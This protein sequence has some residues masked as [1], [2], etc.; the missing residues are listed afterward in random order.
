M[1]FPISLRL[2]SHQ[3]IMLSMVIAQSSQ[4]V[5]VITLRQLSE[6]LCPSPKVSLTLRD[7]E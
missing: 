3:N 5:V 6:T 1:L 4:E 7:S 2:Y